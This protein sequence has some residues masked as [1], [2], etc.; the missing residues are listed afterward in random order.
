MHLVLT[1]FHQIKGPSILVSYPDEK[2]EEDIIKKLIK[3]FDLEIDETF[4]EIVLITKKKKII[5]FH[6]DI[7]SEWARG[8][9]EFVML[10]LIMKREYESEQFYAFIVDSG[11]KIL[12]TENIYKAFYKH[13]D[14]H[15][16]DI[17]IDLNYEIIKKILYNCLISLISRIEDK[18][19]GVNKKEP[20]PFS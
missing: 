5:N 12:K 17:E 11:Y 13:D 1:Y 9:K 18:I 7:D 2:L 8:K 19:K 20:F 6:F 4:F 3:F 14:F 16:N 10:S 15:D